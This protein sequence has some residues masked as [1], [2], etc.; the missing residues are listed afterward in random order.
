[1]RQIIFLTLASLLLLGS[2]ATAADSESYFYL[3]LKAGQS[4]YSDLI[5]CGECETVRSD[6]TQID[7]TPFVYG[8]FAG[9]QWTQYFATEISYLEMGKAEL[10]VTPREVGVPQTSTST[11]DVNS[12]SIDTSAI[13]ILPLGE[14][15]EL[16]AKVGLHYYSASSE[17][18]IVGDSGSEP[19]LKWDDTDLSYGL[20]TNF[21]LTSQWRMGLAYEIYKATFD[22]ETLEDDDD[23]DAYDYDLTTLTVSLSY[24]F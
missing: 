19:S 20:G 12:R 9:Y 21:K 15:F 17:S 2:A 3:G 6:F 8:V 10:S 4:D 1:M 23:V 11:L 14:R 7:D 24:R 13:G 22:N 5:F 16:F 18:R